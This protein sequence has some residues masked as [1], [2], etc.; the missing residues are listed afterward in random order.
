[1]NTGS[2]HLRGRGKGRH[3]TQER[4]KSPMNKR[5]SQATLLACPIEALLRLL[6]FIS[7][8]EDSIQQRT[9]PDGSSEPEGAF[10]VRV[11][12]TILRREKQLSQ[13]QD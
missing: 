10:K 9:Y 12:Q 7:R 13:G 11:I 8:P 3:L 2:K 1:M 6:R 5:L 4:A